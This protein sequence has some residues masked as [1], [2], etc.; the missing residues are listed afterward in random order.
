MSGF[1]IVT[2]GSTGIGRHLVL[3]FAEAGYAVA[4]SFKGDEEASNTLMESV[5]ASGGQALGIECDVGSAAEVDEFFDEVCS[6]YGDER[7]FGK[8]G[9]RR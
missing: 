2:G 3:A 5:E 4:F 1:A 9:Q 6:W 7:W 8:S